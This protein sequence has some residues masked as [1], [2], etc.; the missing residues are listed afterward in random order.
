MTSTASPHR[1]ADD[2]T[3]AQ[4]WS[5]LFGATLLL[6]G[7]AGFFVNSSFDTGSPPAGDDLI[8]FPVN[9]WENIVHIASGA[10]A[11]AMWKNRATARTAA[12]VLGATYLVVA[13]IGFITGDHILTLLPTDGAHNVL[14]LLIGA[15]GI[16]A[17]V[18]SDPARDRRTAAV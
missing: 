15:T 8:I 10:F 3:P 6:V 12:Y 5:L 17:A 13:A 14:H 4:L 11:L 16:A 18:A 9:G 7:I 1:T 2:R